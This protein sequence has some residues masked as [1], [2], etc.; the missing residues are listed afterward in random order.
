MNRKIFVTLFL[1]LTMISLVFG[2]M[3]IAAAGTLNAPAGLT[4][5]FTPTP[6][7]LVP[8]QT[9]TP[10]NTLVPTATSV[11]TATTAPTAIPTNTAAPAATGTPTAQVTDASVPTATPTAPTVV[12]LPDTGG[13]APPGGISAWLLLWI[14]GIM[15]GLGALVFRLNRRNLRS[16]RR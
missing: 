4:E 12:G 1:C 16:T 2:S 7:I 10:T 5:T 13:A 14:A 3:P 15:G 9:S 11:S 8:T 6:V